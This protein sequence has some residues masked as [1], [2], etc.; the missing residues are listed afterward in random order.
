MAKQ[1]HQLDAKVLTAFF[2]AAMPFVAFGSFIVVN[3]A[4][5]LLRES[6]GG[7]LEQRAVRRSSPSSSTSRTRSCTC[8]SWRSIP[9]CSGARAPGPPPPEGE[10]RRAEQAWAQAETPAH[11]LDRRQPARRPH[12]PAGAGATRLPPDPGR[13][14]ARPAGRGLGARRTPVE[15]GDAL[16]QGRGG[17]AGRAEA[18]VGEPFRPAGSSIGAVRD[19]VP[20]PQHAEAF[21]RRHA[22]AR[23]RRG[24]L[25][26]VGP[27]RIGRTGHAV[28]VRA[29]DGLVLAS[30]ESERIL[31]TTFRDSSRCGAPSTASRSATRAGSCSGP[32]ARGAAIGRSRSSGCRRR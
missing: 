30:D 29:T 6:V 7:G 10:R 5:T 15:R 20:R 17:A 31:A 28:L 2:L 16:V 22:G 13:R 3:Q 8:A 23:G 32:P 24:P 4:R 1:R 27:V 25:H 14:R 21:R 19:R 12:A 11:R 26:R 18:H 9:R